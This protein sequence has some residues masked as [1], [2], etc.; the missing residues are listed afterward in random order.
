MIKNRITF[1]IFIIKTLPDIFL[2]ECKKSLIETSGGMIKSDQIQI[3][4]EKESRE[5]TLNAILEKKDTQRDLFIV[6]DDII[7]LN[8][9]YESLINNYIYGDIIGFSMLDAQSGLLQDFGYDFVFVDGELSYRGLYKHKELK[10]LNLPQYR[11]CDAVTGCAM[12]IKKEV[13]SSV[14]KF[15]I[16]G[17]NRWGEL[18][19]SHLAKNKGYNTIVLNANLKHHAIS[20]KQNSNIN[21]SSMSWLVERELWKNVVKEYLSDIKPKITINTTVSKKLISLI[22]EAKQ[23]LIYGAGTIADTILSSLNDKTKIDICSGLKEEVGLQL[24]GIKIKDA[25]RLDPAKYD[26]IIISS[27]GYENQIIDNYFKNINVSTL[28]RENGIISIKNGS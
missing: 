27:V 4:N 16:N 9:W 26:K 18:L 22:D 14:N 28:S 19:F 3:I 8:G 2:I 15:P 11:N 5:K 12:F 24:R 23:C 13:F 25:N 6:A 7:F 20:T 21:K 17:E 1:E 10:E